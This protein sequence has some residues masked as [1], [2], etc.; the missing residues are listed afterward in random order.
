MRLI[1]DSIRA[2][3]LD[4]RRAVDTDEGVGAFFGALFGAF[5][6]EPPSGAFTQPR[7]GRA[8]DGA[9]VFAVLDAGDAVEP[10]EKALGAAA[11]PGRELD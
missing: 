2:A 8:L 11:V 4:A 9:E 7:P 1:F 5:V 3:M 10:G 6:K